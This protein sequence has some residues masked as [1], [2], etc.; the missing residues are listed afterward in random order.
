L[1]SSGLFKINVLKEIDDLG[2]N[3]FYAYKYLV[4]NPETKKARI[5]I[6]T[7]LKNP[8]SLKFRCGNKYKFLVFKKRLV[9]EEVAV[10]HEPILE[11]W[12]SCLQ[13]R[14]FMN[15]IIF[16][17]GTGGRDYHTGEIFLKT[18]N[19]NYGRII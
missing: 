13:S 8:G 11:H 7:P 17:Y 4:Y 2:E 6:I 12:I 14:C 18:K 10:F 5:D 19:L 3:L 15:G 9:K 1:Y 16:I